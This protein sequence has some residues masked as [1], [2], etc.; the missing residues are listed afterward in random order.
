[1]VSYPLLIGSD[2][3][4]CKFKYLDEDKNWVIFGNVVSP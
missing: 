1:M 3:M 2:D 4:Y